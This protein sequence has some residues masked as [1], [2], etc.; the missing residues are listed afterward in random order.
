MSRGYSLGTQIK[1]SIPMI[2]ALR[3]EIMIVLI[4]FLVGVLAGWMVLGWGLAPVQWTDAAPVHLRST[5]GTTQDFRPFHLKLLSIAYQTNRISAEDLVQLGIGQQYTTDMLRADVEQLIASDPGNA[6]AYQALLSAV[7]TQRAQSQP[8][9]EPSAQPEAN[10]SSLPLLLLL[11]FAVLAIAFLGFQIVRRASLSAQ[12]QAVGGPGGTAAGRGPAA[13]RSLAAADWPGETEP[14]LKQFDMTYVLGDDRFD[15]SNAIET[16]QGMFLGECGM[17]ISETIGVGD[18][19]KVTAFE[20]WLFDKNDIRT[21][22]TVLMSH[23]AF[24]DPTLRAKLAAKGEAALA[25]LNEAVK[26]STASLRVRAKVVELDYGVGTLPDRSFFQRL[27][28][29]MAAWPIGDGGVTQPA[30]SI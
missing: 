1:A 22:T 28:V 4:V 14:P 29:V 10:G 8:A 13:T 18:P 25:Q 15:M 20:V 6:A 27:R 24:N 21:V 26:L 11:A 30:P 17:G 16:A 5:S 12:A 23:H 7:E 9:G 3:R 2:K 19:D